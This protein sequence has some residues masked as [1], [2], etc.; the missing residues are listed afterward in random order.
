MKKLARSFGDS[1]RIQYEPA[2]EA[3]RTTDWMVGGYQITMGSGG[4]CSAGF[5]AVDGY[6]RNVVVTAGH[7]TAGGGWVSRN[8]YWVGNTRSSSFPTDDFG[9]FWNAYPSYW[10]P[11]PLGRCASAMRRE[12]AAGTPPRPRRCG[13]ISCTP[14]GPPSPIPPSSGSPT[15]HGRSTTGNG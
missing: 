6:N 15:D 7:C 3:P 2:S 1:V 8:G 14:C 13:P 4:Y 10:Q 9:T 11:S 12:P 5:N